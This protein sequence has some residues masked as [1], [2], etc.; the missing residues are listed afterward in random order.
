MPIFYAQK[1][2]EED[3]LNAA[4]HGDFQLWRSYITMENCSVVNGS[5]NIWQICVSSFNQMDINIIIFDGE[6]KKHTEP[7]W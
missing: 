2:F 4:G 6:T 7:C 5:C 3:V 1:F